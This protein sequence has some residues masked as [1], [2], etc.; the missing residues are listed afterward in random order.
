MAKKD[1][2][3]YYEQVC[4]QYNE[5][6]NNLKELEEYARTNVVAPETIDNLKT[7]I[8]PIKT[9]YMTLSYI[10]FLLNA[11]NK[12]KK[13]KSYVKQNKQKLKDTDVKYYKESILNR[14]QIILDQMGV[15][16]D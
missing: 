8:E 3:V 2:E 15:K 10:M 4:A 7:V 5:M 11:P 6:V 12:T 14:S 9:N 13:L 16:N 1:I